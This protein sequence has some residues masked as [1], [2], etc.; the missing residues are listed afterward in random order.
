MDKCWLP[1]IQHKS[2][3]KKI[4]CSGSVEL[5]IHG[6]NSRLLADKLVYDS[7]TFLVEATSNVTI[8]R[9]NFACTGSSFKFRIDS[10]EYLVTNP[11]VRLRGVAFLLRP[12]SFDNS[13]TKICTFP[14]PSAI[15]TASPVITTHPAPVFDTEA[16]RFYK[17]WSDKMSEMTAPSVFDYSQVVKWYGSAARQ[18]QS[19]SGTFWLFMPKPSRDSLCERQIPRERRL[20]QRI[21]RNSTAHL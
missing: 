7:Q 21:T 12:S 13:P 18:K 10:D 1:A 17:L 6:H 4:F 16:S 11:S 8:M 3:E 5:T 19:L 2:P 9:G 20:N 15:I 14:A